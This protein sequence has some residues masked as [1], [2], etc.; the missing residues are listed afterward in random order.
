MIHDLFMR[1]AKALK[2]SS[3]YEKPKKF[4]FMLEH[5]DKFEFITSFLTK[6]EITREL[7]SSHGLDYDRIDKFWLEFAQ[8]SPV[9]GL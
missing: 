4:A 1:Q 2:D 6:A 9:L 8:K 3:E 7:A 5:Q